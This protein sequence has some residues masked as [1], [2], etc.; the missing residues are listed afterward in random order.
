MWSIKINGIEKHIELA[1]GTTLTYNTTNPAFDPEQT[2]NAYT[3]SFTIPAT[4][5]N[6]SI[7]KYANRMDRH[8][9]RY[10]K[11]WDATL[12]VEGI[13]FKYGLFNILKDNPKSFEA[14]FKTPKRYLLDKLSNISLASLSQNVRYNQY[15]AFEEGKGYQY[16]YFEF[17]GDD[18]FGSE[19]WFEITIKGVTYT[20]PKWAKGTWNSWGN[21]IKNTK[22]EEFADQINTELGLEIATTIGDDMLSIVIRDTVIEISD[23]DVSPSVLFISWVESGFRSLIRKQEMWRYHTQTEIRL[24]DSYN[25]IFPMVLASGSAVGENAGA[26]K[27]FNMASGDAYWFHLPQLDGGHPKFKTGQY[28]PMPKCRWIFEQIMDKAGV[29]GILGEVINNVDVQSTILFSNVNM[30]RTQA[31]PFKEFNQEFDRSTIVPL[32]EWDLGWTLPDKDA[33][34]FLLVFCEFFGMYWRYIGTA[35]EF[36]K[37]VDQLHNSQEDWTNRCEPNWTREYKSPGAQILKY[38]DVEGV[39]PSETQL[40]PYG[41]EGEIIEL[42]ANTLPYVISEDR[43]ANI[44]GDGWIW[45]SDWREWKTPFWSGPAILAGVENG[46]RKRNTVPAYVF[47]FYR[48]YQMDNVGDLYCYASHD[49][50]DYNGDNV[51]TLDLDMNAEEYSIY[52]D[53]WKDIFNQKNT[54]KI[55][56]PVRLGI[57]DL[58]NI[59]K[60][61]HTVKRIYTNMGTIL[62]VVMSVEAIFISDVWQTEIIC[63][64]EFG[65]LR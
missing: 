62:G 61:T 44:I 50:T 26:K 53:R 9:I 38:P 16:G 4:P 11:E 19:V 5:H 59:E 41:T 3:Y 43:L 52:E 24:D 47:L 10:D 33:K 7:V 46:Q 37:K 17:A 56:I 6:C 20:S 14:E 21:T 28:V 30:A 8:D 39:P 27:Y 45:E 2:E 55:T 35:I 22:L 1:P 54:D 18:L 12:M 57:K 40:Q 29:T 15:D 58:I 51:G 34:E 31:G 64:V 13:P 60:W 63:N 49:T 65:V 48:G 23:G 36:V 42:P 25:Y 32:I